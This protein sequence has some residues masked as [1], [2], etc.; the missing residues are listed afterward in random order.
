MADQPAGRDY[1]ETLF[2]PET[3]FPMRAGLP[4]KEPQWIARWKEIGLYQKLREDGRSR[5]KFVLHDGP[6]YANGAIH[7]GH[8]EN[9]I[10]KDIVVRSRQ[11]TGFD[12]DYVPGWD[13]HGLPIEWKVEEEFRKAGRDKKDVDPV[14]FRKM[15]RQ[16]ADKWIPL[17]KEEFQRLGIEGDWDN[18]YSTMSF[19]AEAAIAE[20]F[21]KVVRTGLVY[22]GSKPVMW[23]PVE[24]TSLAEAEVEYAEKTSTTIW[25][26][27][28][29]RQVTHV[30][31]DTHDEELYFSTSVVIWT[32]TPWTIPGNRAISYSPKI[33]YGIYE[34]Q[35]IEPDLQF[36]PWVKVGEKLA[37][38]DN[39]AD[40]VLR[41]AKAA[42][43]KRVAEFVPSRAVCAHP[44]RNWA[45][46]LPREG[47]VAAQRPE[48]AVPPPQSSLRDDSAPSQGSTGGYAFPVPLL[49]GDHVTDDAGTGFVH[50]APGHG[51]DDFNIWIEN[52][53]QEGIPF[54]V[55]EEG[56]FTKEA[57]GF[58]TLEVVRLDGKNLGKDGPAN[59]AV[60]DALIA[61]GNLLA[62]GT[63]KH[64]YPHSWRSH[65][66]LIFRNTAQ[67][68]VALDKPYRDGKTLRQVALS[69]IDR[70]DWGQRRVNDDAYQNRIKSMVAERPDWL[71]SRQRN[72]GVPLPIFV[73]KV[74]GAILMDDAVDARIVAAMKKGGADV[75][76]STPAQDFLGEKYNAADFEKVEDILDVWFDSGCTHAFV[77]ETKDTLPRPASVYLEGSDQHRGWFQSSLL[78]SCAT[79]GMAPYN[80]VITY[81]FTVDEQGRKMSKSLGNGVEPQ[82]VEK[83]WGIEIFRLL[84]AAADF[85][86]ELRIGKTIFDQS[87]EMYRKLRNTLRYLLGALKGYSDDER[88]WPSPLVGEGGLAEQDRVRGDRETASGAGANT[89]HPSASL[90]PSPTRGEGVPLLERWLLHR[91]WEV[92]QAVRKGYETYEFHHA[93]SAIVEFCNVDL[94]AFYVDVRKDSLYC[95]R[96]DSLKRR[97]CRTAL[98]EVFMRL[99]AWLAPV[100]PFTADEAWTTRFASPVSVHLRQF[101]ETPESW[102]DDDAAKQMETLRAARSEVTAA[103]EGARREKKIG[104]SLE[105]RPRLFVSAE[106]KQALEA[107]DFAELC[108]TSGVDIVA[109]APPKTA[110]LSQSLPNF[111]VLIEPARGRKCARSWKFSEDVGADPRYPDL[112]AR[113]ADAVAW[114]D[115]QR[116]A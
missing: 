88:V 30:S 115:A 79:R 49:A 21:L 86:D 8:A 31:G 14:E 73:S 69:E 76:W 25:V 70:V 41:A 63:L 81:G 4:Q 67:W 84:I 65:A 89:P 68:F 78:E 40:E 36:Q 18:Y 114:W 26:K 29:I 111:A 103:L 56:R 57:P 24:R 59:K 43:W 90:T 47:E 39:L 108:I 11:M 7:I 112:S 45:P 71:V 82:E 34:V 13:C 102:R 54:T 23:S 64:Q 77:L 110:A 105:A 33:S 16:Y 38:A 53:G 107:V 98:D 22:R 94:S 20:E 60:I 109:G 9:K 35:S 97:A 62:R 1:R 2:L 19:A 32:T 6:P 101:P 95:D 91:L 55:D 75:W 80:E 42:T 28:P 87:A 104:A 5:P 44:L 100:M 72:W 51:A 12:S 92:D 113:D 106:M 10:L 46:V 74:D 37:I 83:Q 52:F 93:I 50:T 58:E 85:R 99:T 48:G 17:Q 116:A 96:R 61:S 66:P 3:D 15:C 27:F